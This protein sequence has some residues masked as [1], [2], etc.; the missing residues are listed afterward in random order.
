MLFGFLKKLFINRFDIVH[1]MKMKIGTITFAIKFAIF[2]RKKTIRKLN[3][4]FLMKYNREYNERTS[5]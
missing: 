2:L 4:K 1:V 3:T 5:L